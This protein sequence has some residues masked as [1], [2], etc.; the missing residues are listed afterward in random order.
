MRGEKNSR[1][2]KMGIRLMLTPEEKSYYDNLFLVTG[3]GRIGLLEGREG[4]KFFSTSGLDR[5]TLHKIWALSDVEQRGSLDQDGFSAACRLIAHAQSKR[6]PEAS[7]V[8]VQP[9]VLPI[10]EGLKRNALSNPRLDVPLDADVIS[11]SDFGND[12]V[13]VNHI[14]T[15]RAS[16]IARSLAKLGIDPLEFIPFQS[17]PDTKSS[18]RNPTDWKMT[19]VN[20]QKYTGL[21]NQL[22]TIAGVVEGKSA[23]KLLEKS[24][25]V[26]PVLGLIWEM[27]DLNRDGNLNL[28]EFLIAMQITTK[29]K[30]GAS[31]P[32]QVPNELLEQVAEIRLEKPTKRFTSNP[33]VTPNWKYTSSRNNLDDYTLVENERK[34]KSALIGDVDETEEEMRY[35][36]D[37]CSQIENDTSRLKI[38]IDKRTSLVAELEREKR[39]LA[40]RKIEVVDVRKRMNVDKISLGRDKATLESEIAHLNKLISESSADVD[41]LRS[42][43]REIEV[44][45]DRLLTQTSSLSLQRKD[46]VRQ[47][48][49]ELN[50]IES[51]QKETAALVDSF[52]Q[53]G[54]EEEVRLQSEKLR[55]ESQKIISEMQRNPKTNV[56][57]TSVF[58]SDAKNKWATTLLTNESPT[59]NVGFGETFFQ[60]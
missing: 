37:L 24:G 9:G 30:K 39:L 6:A 23:R 19:E 14:D 51:E 43:V 25:L 54:R 10:F 22:A 31:L 45:V 4:A 42:S 55:N 44:D 46:A 50:K 26:K 8:N 35:T 16:V 58:S 33:P 1:R 21:F 7:L 56:Q 11:V 38:E 5:D 40:E 52:Q 60:K 47:H 28:S 17:G 48:S 29:C 27:S 13:S 36:F 57:S 41:I 32:D 34:L 18:S 2:N 3:A 49:E 53:L 12:G 20:R 59:K 15:D